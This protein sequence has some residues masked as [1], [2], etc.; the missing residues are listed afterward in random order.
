VYALWS[1]G[2]RRGGSNAIPLVGPFGDNP[3]LITYKPDE[4]DNYEIGLKG[5][6]ANGLSYTVDVFKIYWD[7]PQIG[8]TTP[9][10]N[11][12]VW[13]ADEAISKGFEL[14]LNMPF[15]DTGLSLSLSGAYSDAAFSKDYT[16]PSTFGDIVGF[17]GQQLPGSPKESGAA[18]LNYERDVFSNFRLSASLNDTYRSEVVLSNFGI[19]GQ[20]PLTADKLNLL[21]ASLALSRDNWLVGLYATNLTN[22]RVL[23]SP[24]NPDPST[25]NLS[26]SSLINQPREV[27]LRLNYSF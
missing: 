7:N 5:H 26:T 20:A 13:N 12:A 11:F 23:L 18:T 21:N 27:S 6:F 4:A 15:G 3:A 17:K 22:E 10:T 2:F 25:D 24:G 1:Q 16:V 19:L 14:D 8:G 9:T